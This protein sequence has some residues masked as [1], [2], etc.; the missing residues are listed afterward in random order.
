[1]RFNRDRCQLWFKRN[2]FFLKCSMENTSRPISSRQ[3]INSALC[4]IQPKPLF[5]SRLERY[6]NLI[7]TLIMRMLS[8]FLL[9]WK[10]RGRL[11][12]ESM[13]K[14]PGEKYTIKLNSLH[15]SKLNNIFLPLR[16]SRSTHSCKKDTK[17]GNYITQ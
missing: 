1:M 11:S 4:L 2:L 7:S 17:V 12:S 15:L 8:S 5:P 10:I 16:G 6:K 3:T 13:R 14:V 9:Y